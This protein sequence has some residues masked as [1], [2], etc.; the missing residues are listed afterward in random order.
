MYGQDISGGA[1]L[2]RYQPVNLEGVDGRSEV[3]AAFLR[4]RHRASSWELYVEARARD[5]RL[6]TFFPGNVWFQEAWVAYHV[7]EEE[8]VT[9]RLLAGKTYQ[10]TGRF[11]D[12]SFFGNLHYFDGLKL[13]PQWVVEAS[14]TWWAD[15]FRVGYQAQYVMNSDRVSGAFQGRD[16]ETLDGVRDQHGLGGRA[17]LGLPLGIRFGVTVFGRGVGLGPLRPS[18]G[19]D[20]GTDR[21]WHLGGDVEFTRGPF[22][23]YAEWTHRTGGDL[24]A[25]LRRTI[26]GSEAEYL[27]LGAQVDRGSLHLRYNASRANYDDLG[28]VEW[29]HQ[30]G[31]TYDLSDHVS[32]LTEINVW[33]GEDR[34]GQDDETLDQSLNLVLLITF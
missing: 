22:T 25:E 11:W 15:G 17:T 14:G 29:I 23:G 2:F 7:T 20:P 18:A 30:P 12:G 24:P 13:N 5:D 6:R 9:L 8:P 10:T 34:N 27:L 31:V 26:A 33:T 1:Y 32:A 16:F 28:R 3:Y 4:A 19:P 21:T